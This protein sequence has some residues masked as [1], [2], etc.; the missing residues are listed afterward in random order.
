MELHTGIQ[1]MRDTLREL[2]RKKQ[3]NRQIEL[4]LSIVDNKSLGKPLFNYPMNYKVEEVQTDRPMALAFATTARLH[5][6]PNR[7]PADDYACEIVF[8][9]RQ[10]KILCL[11]ITE[12]ERFLDVLINTP[13]FR[14][15][16]KLEHYPYWNNTDK[17][18]DVTEPEWEQ[19]KFEWNTAFEN[20][21]PALSG[22]IAQLTQA[23]IRPI[24]KDEMTPHDLPELHTRAHHLA[25]A[26]VLDGK[27]KTLLPANPETHDYSRAFFDASDW[28]KTEEGQQQV[29]TQTTLIS[30]KLL[31]TEQ[32]FKAM[33]EPLTIQTGQNA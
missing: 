15:S 27:M 13:W 10:D 29:L 23:N 25:K 18:D 11:I 9:P 3:K 6:S 32:A 26:A 33:F 21:T 1:K 14:D 19:R 20:G 5:K 22:F 4:A 31:D 16:S 24:Y 30:T 2:A 17:P 8:L 12:D 7:E 28:I